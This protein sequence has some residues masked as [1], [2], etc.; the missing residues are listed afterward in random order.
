MKSTEPVNN[1]LTAIWIKIKLFKSYFA[2]I[3]PFY[4]VTNV[5]AIPE[6]IFSTGEDKSK[7]VQTSFRSRHRTS[8]CIQRNI[9]HITKCKITFK[10]FYGSS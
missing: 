3:E 9:G 1:Y 6:S 2:G 7:S 8:M 5:S 10:D 4:T